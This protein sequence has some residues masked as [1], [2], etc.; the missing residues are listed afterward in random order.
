MNLRIIK[1]T[2]A[3]NQHLNKNHIKVSSFI[4]CSFNDIK[5]PKL[6]KDINETE[7]FLSTI[8]E[9]LQHILSKL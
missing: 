3:K 2:F 4:F 5:N 9:T 7:S 1:I 8:K 6:I